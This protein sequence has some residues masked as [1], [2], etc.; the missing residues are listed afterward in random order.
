M[1]CREML[2]ENLRLNEFEGLP[3]RLNCVFLLPDRADADAY[4]RL[5]NA[6]GRQILHE[7]ELIDRSSPTQ[8]G[9]ISHC[10]MQSGASFLEQMEPKGRAYWSG[11]IGDIAQGR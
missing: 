9:W 6:D 4:G 1:L 7:V 10:T 5:N 11:E 2:W 8:T 3:S